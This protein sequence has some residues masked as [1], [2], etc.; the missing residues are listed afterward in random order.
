MK[1]LLAYK[2]DL[3]FFLFLRK[4]VTKDNIEK[5]VYAVRLLILCKNKNRLFECF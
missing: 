5:C 1:I 2:F 4:T 3:G